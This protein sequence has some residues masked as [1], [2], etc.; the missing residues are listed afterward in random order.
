M[1]D[2]IKMIYKIIKQQFATM[3]LE[4]D[5]SMSPN[6]VVTAILKEN[7]KRDGPPFQVRMT[8]SMAAGVT[9]FRD[10]LHA[11]RSASPEAFDELLDS[12]R[13]AGMK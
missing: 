8:D 3:G 1:E 13:T 9:N 10:A 5:P 7:N 6:R 11:L 4:P 2:E 12:L